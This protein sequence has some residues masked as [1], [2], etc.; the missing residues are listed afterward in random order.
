MMP[1]FPPNPPP[2]MA[3]LPAPPEPPRVEVVRLPRVL[4]LEEVDARPPAH[5]RVRDGATVGRSAHNDLRLAA[6][7][8]S[9]EHAALAFNGAAWEVRPRPGTETLLNRAPVTHAAALTEGDVLQ[10]GQQSLKV[11]F[12]AP[13]EVLAPPALVAAFA[14]RGWAV[15]FAPAGVA[16]RLEDRGSLRFA[17]S[18]DAAEHLAVQ[19]DSADGGAPSCRYQ[20]R[21]ANA[22]IAL[23]VPLDDAA[24][25]VFAALRALLTAIHH[26]ARRRVLSPYDVI[27][28][29][30]DEPGGRG[31]WR[32]H[33]NV[34]GGGALL[35]ALAD[36]AAHVS[37][38]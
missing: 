20:L 36:A 18:G 6:P 33:H 17:T 26:A 15:P 25:G 2:V 7:S 8:V 38:H 31:R 5:H 4:Y 12:R 23:V 1:F 19:V 34:V 21:C 29:E 9:R 24:R 28:F 14:R 32:T 16:G 37:A 10:L 3:P 13:A 35:D 11:T 22:D 27:R 30:C